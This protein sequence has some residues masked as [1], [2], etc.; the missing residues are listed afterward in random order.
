MKGLIVNEDG[1]LRLADDLPVPEI[2]PYEAL[3][4]TECCMICNGTDLE[5]IKGD[6]P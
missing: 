5:I 3:V 4:K 2:G 6:C 1:S